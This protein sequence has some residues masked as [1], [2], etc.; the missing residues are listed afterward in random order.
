MTESE[1]KFTV[2]R[3]KHWSRKAAEA[4]AARPHAGEVLRVP[5]AVEEYGGPT[6]YFYD[7][8]C[9]T[10]GKRWTEDQ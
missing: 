7:C 4:R 8:E 10:C 3:A 1:I 5:F 6:E 2:Q 9:A